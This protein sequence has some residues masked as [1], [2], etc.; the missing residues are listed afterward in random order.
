MPPIKPAIN[1]KVTFG[2]WYQ[3]TTLHLTEV[4]EFLS[5]ANT[6]LDLDKTKLK[7]LHE[8]LN[9][10]EVTR[11]FDYLEY[12][13]ATTK[14]GIE[15]RY[16][17]DGLYI[18]EMSSINIQHAKAQLENYY[19]T[20]L[21]P[22]LCYIF[23]LGAPLPK[24][25]ANIQTKH[26]TVISFEKEFPEQAAIDTDVFGKI[27]TQVI[28]D[29]VGVFKTKDYIF[30]VN[31]PKSRVPVKELVEMQIFF[32]EFKDQ[33]E[34][35]LNIHRK[36]WS[37][38][39]NIKD[40]KAIKPKEVPTLRAKLDSYQKTIS[41]ITNRINQMGSYVR[42]RKAIS[43]KAGAD[44][45]LNDLFQYR[46]EVLIDTL[47]YIKEIWK[48]TTDYVNSAIA[49]MNEIQSWATNKSIQSLTTIT[50]VGVIGGLFLHLSRETF[51]RVTRA[52]IGYLALLLIIATVINIA[53][54]LLQSNVKR[55]MR[56]VDREEEI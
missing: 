55:K 17:E 43:Q 39:S 24:V 27:Y 46:F 34:K 41:L 1:Y 4:Y 31:K 33:L 36:V 30:I 22:A 15:I 26:P 51:P 29:G 28:R 10:I 56:F 19:H 50:S 48:M 20:K 21:N 12:I 52:G 49:V 7:A 38:I 13:K 32:R 37:D 6:Y 23:S 44:Q 3:R 45:H 47:D 9:I 54:R 53:V 25:L 35:Y 18:L 5:V 42:T 11:E 40:R 14:E 2:G 16:Y 8:K